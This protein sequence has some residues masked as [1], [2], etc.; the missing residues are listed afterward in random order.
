METTVTRMLATTIG[1]G[2]LSS[3]NAP[4]AASPTPPPHTTNRRKA[5]TAE[6]AATVVGPAGA[7]PVP[8]TVCGR[9]SDRCG[10]GTVTG[11]SGQN[12]GGDGDA[13]PPRNP[14]TRHRPDGGGSPR[15]L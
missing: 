9:R 8:A 12:R 6:G 15:I 4:P 13:I 3:I 14:P 11:S 5:A 1:I 2:P 7:V 10:A